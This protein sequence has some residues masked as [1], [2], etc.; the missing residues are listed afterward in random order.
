MRAQYPESDGPGSRP[1]FMAVDFLQLVGPESVPCGRCNTCRAGTFEACRNP[2][3]DSLDIRERI[4]RASYTAHA[5]A[6]QYDA[7]VWL[8]SSVARER[9]NLWKLL[10]QAAPAWNLDDGGRPVDRRIHNPD[11][12]VGLGKE[13]GE[14]EYSAD[15]VSA[16]IRVPD[17]WSG[18]GCDVVFATAKGRATGASWSP[19]RFTGFGYEDSP[20]G[21]MSATA[22]L[23]PDDDDEKEQKKQEQRQQRQQRVNSER[24]DRDAAKEAA[25]RQRDDEDDAAARKIVAANPEATMR[26][27]VALLRK[28]RACGG[29]RAFAAVSRVRGG[30]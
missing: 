11:A 14:I 15:S 26:E 21:G 13:S 12:L 1:I 27:L 28:E 20:D 16:I 2:Q 7:A 25:K 8:I 30:R 3:P 5:V 10:E 18:T 9:Y 22:A 17:S 6:E 29:D 23:E 4:A 24:A 19:V